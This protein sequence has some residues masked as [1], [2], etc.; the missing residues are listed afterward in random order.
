MLFKAI[1]QVISGALALGERLVGASASILSLH[2]EN[3][4]CSCFSV[5]VFHSE[6]IN[7]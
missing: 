7:F 6:H 2:S 1:Q 4:E 3:V 5:R